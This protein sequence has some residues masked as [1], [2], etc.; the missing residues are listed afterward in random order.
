MSKKI[1]D[2]PYC[3]D[4]LSAQYHAFCTSLSVMVKPFADVRLDSL[5]DLDS[6]CDKSLQ[7]V[8]DM[9]SSDEGFETVWMK[10]LS[11]SSFKAAAM[12]GFNEFCNCLDEQPTMKILR[13]MTRDVLLDGGAR[14]LSRGF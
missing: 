8:L 14:L 12:V 2:Q 10:A 9:D 11:S 5:F 3:H 6:E 13:E 4:D 1:A 7:S